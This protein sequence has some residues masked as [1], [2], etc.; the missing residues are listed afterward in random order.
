MPRKYQPSSKH[1]SP[2]GFGT[3]CP[4]DLELATSQ[5]LLESAVQ[6]GAALWAVS[7]PWCFK[8]FQTFPHGP[9][10]EI[11]HGFPVVGCEVPEDVIVALRSAGQIDLHQCRSIRKQRVLPGAWA[12]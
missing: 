12:A 11:W 5:A 3:L 9:D 4:S 7:G 6:V 8:A 1:K 2:K 10:P